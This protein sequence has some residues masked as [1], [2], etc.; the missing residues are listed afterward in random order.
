[1]TKFRDI[2]GKKFGFYGV[3]G[4]LFKLGRWIF[5]ALEDEQDGWRSSLD[6]I[7]RRDQSDAI[8]FKRALAQVEVQEFDEEYGDDGWRFV[9]V[10][11]GHVWLAIGTNYNDDYY[12]CFYFRYHAKEKK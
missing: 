8:F 4:N 10:K 9:D 12:P 1:M 3:D 11:D 5:E 7:E 2:V 6:D